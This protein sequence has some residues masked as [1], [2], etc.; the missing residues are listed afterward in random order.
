MFE[1]DMSVMKKLLGE[2][3][4]SENGR[5]IM[6][7]VKYNQVSKVH[8]I[9]LRALLEG[10]GK[11][12]LFVT[13][14]R[15]HQYMEYLLKLNRIDHR[16]LTFLDMISNFS[17]EVPNRG[18]NV[19]FGASPFG[20]AS[21]IDMLENGG[22]DVEGGSVDVA[23][24]DFLMMDNLSSMLI[25]NSMG[26]V[27]SFLERYLRLI[28]RYGTLFTAIVIEVNSDPKLYECLT[29]L[30][31]KCFQFTDDGQLQPLNPTVPE[32]AP[33]NEQVSESIIIFAPQK[34]TG[35]FPRPSG[36]GA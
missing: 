1:K 33:G 28:E 22:A 13:V 12:G 11:R 15:P 29:R 18:A 6:L 23:L 31:Q 21:L 19:K 7:A 9:V 36:A 8:L 3:A 24:L 5:R 35:P 34:R 14:D 2:I 32:A 10:M 16:N 26:E 4:D 30:C 27:T 25:Y 17:G 20:I